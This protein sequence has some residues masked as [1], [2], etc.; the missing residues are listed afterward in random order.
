MKKRLFYIIFLIL[1]ADIAIAEDFQNSK[2]V[3]MDLSIKG[4]IDIHPTLSNYNIDYVKT[5]LYFKPEES[6]QQKIITSEIDPDANINDNS[7]NFEWNNIANNKLNF[8]TDYRI[9]ANNQIKKIKKKKTFPIETIPSE[10]IHYTKPTEKIDSDNKDIIKLASSIAEGED[11][12]Y[13]VTN[14]IASWV[15]DSITYSLNTMTAEVSQKAS[16]VLLNKFG[17]CD[18]LTTLFIAM[19]R[20]IGIPARFVSGVAFTDWDNLNNWG[21]HAWAELYYP[22]YGWVPYDIAYKQFGYID[23]S[24]I[25]LRQSNDSSDPSIGS[26]WKGHGILV[27]QK[28]LD[29]TVNL[30]DKKESREQYLSL[31]ANIFEEDI[32]F[33][34]YNLLEVNIQ[35]LNDYYYSTEIYLSKSREVT[36]V[37]SNT[38]HI[39]VKPREQKTEYWM[40]K[41]DDDLNKKYIYTLPL[42]IV[43]SKN[44]SSSIYFT[45]A[46]DNIVYTRSEMQDILNKKQKKKT[47]TLSYNLKLNCSTEKNEYYIDEQVI[48]NCN[49]KNIGNTVLNN[50]ELC[51]DKECDNFNLEI[52]QEHNKIYTVNLSDT[53]KKEKIVTIENKDISELARIQF[54]VLDKPSI[55]ITSLE[56]PEELFYNDEF[57]VEFTLF[58]SSV[59]KPEQVVVEFKGPGISKRWDIKTLNKDQ[60][61][62]VNM[63]A[64]DLNAGKNSFNIIV[65]YEDSNG[66]SFTTKEDFYITLSNL[67]IMQRIIIFLRNLL[68]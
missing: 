38:R 40:I 54:T 23:P 60:D 19:L 63:F 12:L 44:E 9:T 36:L 37:D 16:W 50:L 51:L 67:N 11:D 6:F 35:N 31:E 2:E 66:S 22:D 18:E 25:K 5:Y 59:T 32:G 34:S 30:V 28:D 13:I 1:L 24:H 29:I 56:Y 21:P 27:E 20:S 7:V 43:T 4:E 47:K 33:G 68:L 41:V 49:V 15:E 48:V 61:F 8:K 10:Y 42:G 3:T 46:Y 14:N 57:N 52:S 45:A 55:H 26:E 58:K 53:G 17:V 62:L 64:K 65:T 39:V